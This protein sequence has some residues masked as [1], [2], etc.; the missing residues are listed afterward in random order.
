MQISS[1][2]SHQLHL[3]VLTHIS[4][5]GVIHPYRSESLRRYQATKQRGR[6]VVELGG[7]GKQ[8]ENVTPR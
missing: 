3:M 7:G 2:N 8:A 5:N 4:P 1:R 6:T